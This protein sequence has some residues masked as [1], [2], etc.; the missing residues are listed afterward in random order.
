MQETYT[1]LGNESSPYLNVLA[2]EVFQWIASKAKA[3]KSIQS[4]ALR[5]N[6]KTVS[7][8]V[9]VVVGDVISYVASQVEVRAPRRKVFKQTIPV[10]YED[11]HLAV[12][13]KPGGLPVNGNMF[14]TLE[15]TLTINL[16]PSHEPDALEIMRPLHRLDSPTCGLVMV[17]KTERAQVAMGHQFE[18]KE[19]R[20]R[21]QAVVVGQVAESSGTLTDI[22]DDKPSRSDYEV[23]RVSP[24][25]KYDYLSLV[26]LYP[27]T[28]RTHQLRIHMA[29]LGHPIVGDKLYSGQI[30][31]LYGKGLLLCSDRLVFV[32]PITNKE[33]KVEI[34]IPNKFTGIMD[35]EA[36]RAAS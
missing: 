10:V 14:K 25:Q 20:K 30:D 27:V 22:V 15:N 23:I 17:A 8:D 1:V 31:V 11:D 13:N 28:G 24:S 19:I 32:H 9:R 29:N 2:P 12:L 21:Y 34:P 6:G 26:H 5:V 35:R 4:G 7:T 3:R 33:V 36:R 18:Y 16:K